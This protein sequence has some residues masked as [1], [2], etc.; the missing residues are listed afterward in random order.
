MVGVFFCTHVIG[1]NASG[2]RKMELWNKQ[3]NLFFRDIGI[4]Y[5]LDIVYFERLRG[6]CIKEVSTYLW[7]D[8]SNIWFKW[9]Y[10]KELQCFALLRRRATWFFAVWAIGRYILGWSVSKILIIILSSRV[11]TSKNRNIVYW[12]K[13]TCAY[14]SNYI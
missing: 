11:S 13:E 4:Q 1:T 7:V 6:N 12:S 9:F 5:W 14:E 8:P 10:V 2:Y 3:L